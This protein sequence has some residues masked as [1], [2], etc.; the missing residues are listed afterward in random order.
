MRAKSAGE[1]G[2]GLG[3]GQGQ[4]GAAR[5]GRAVGGVGHG[6]EDGRFPPPRK[7][8]KIPGAAG[9]VRCPRCPERWTGRWS[10]RWTGRWSR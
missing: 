3:R 9:S 5:E 8:Q 4:R 7:A 10:G 1:V 6:P 2:G